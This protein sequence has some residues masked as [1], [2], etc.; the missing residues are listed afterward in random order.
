[1]VVQNTNKEWPNYDAVAKDIFQR[2]RPALLTRLTGGVAVG[3]T[4]NV[5]FAVVKSR[6]ADLFELDN[7]ELF[8]LDFQSDNDNEME[9]RIGIDTI[10]GAR[11]TKRR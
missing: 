6:R 3:K 8:L 2:N 4:L 11:S 5:E 9:Y 10:L 7:N 1:M